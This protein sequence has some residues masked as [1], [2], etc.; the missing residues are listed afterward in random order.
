MHLK[1]IKLNCFYSLAYTII[2]LCHLNISSIHTVFI[3]IYAEF[4]LTLK[5]NG[6]GWAKLRQRIRGIVDLI[7][8]FLQKQRYIFS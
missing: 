4:Q 2:R 6:D 3:F 5:S 7:V 1:L 8:R